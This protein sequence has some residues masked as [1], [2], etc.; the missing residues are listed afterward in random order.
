M[1]PEQ[2]DQIIQSIRLAMR[3][4]ESLASSGGE[5]GVTE[6]AKELSVT[7]EHEKADGVSLTTTD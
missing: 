5:K 2:D 6:L 1:L 7:V 3:I 4:L